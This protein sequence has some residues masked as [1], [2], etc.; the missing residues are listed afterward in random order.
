MSKEETKPI[1]VKVVKEEVDET[2]YDDGYTDL[3][4]TEIEMEEDSIG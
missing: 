3:Y 2:V 4:P 1:E